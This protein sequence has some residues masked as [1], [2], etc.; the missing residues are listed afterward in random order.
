MA[1]PLILMAT[2][3]EATT[4]KALIG[5]EEP[6]PETPKTRGRKSGKGSNQKKQPQ[7]GLGVAQLERL[8]ME[9]R[10]KKM[11]EIPQQNQQ[12]HQQPLNL[13][14]HYNFQK[15]QTTSSVSD[16]LG[17]VPVQFGASNYGGGPVVINSS[18]TGL[19][20]FERAGLVVQ[21]IG[22]G[23]G[24]S[25][26]NVGGTRMDPIM[27]DPNPYGIIGAPDQRLKL[28][29]NFNETSKELSS[30]PKMHST[31]VSSDHCDICCK[32]FLPSLFVCLASKKI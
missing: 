14:D 8:R 7:R 6:K 23:G 24:S 12:Q 4:N 32:V 2:E 1:S 29:A 21:R 25:G 13:L 22:N 28:A 3:Q 20:G 19:F 9:E 17:S 16:P 26:I 31:S 15:V 30:M 27:L 11:T 10:L 5:S 18:G